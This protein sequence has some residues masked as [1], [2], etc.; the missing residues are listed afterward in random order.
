MVTIHHYMAITPIIIIIVRTKKKGKPNNFLPLTY[1]LSHVEVENN[2]MT[3]CQDVNR[4]IFKLFLS[5]LQLK[6]G[7]TIIFNHTV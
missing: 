3:I 4:F 1:V 6:H 2:I 5:V 7:I